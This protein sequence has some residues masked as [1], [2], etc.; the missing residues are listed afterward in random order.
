MQYTIAA[1]R[2]FPVT[3]TRAVIWK[4]ISVLKSH[5]SNLTLRRL[6][7]KLCRTVL[8]KIFLIWIL[9][10]EA[11]VRLGRMER[12]SDCQA[13][14]TASSL[15]SSAKSWA[16]V[17]AKEIWLSLQCSI[18]LQDTPSGGS[19]V[20]IVSRL[21]SNPHDRTGVRRPPHARGLG[22]AGR[23]FGLWHSHSICSL[24]RFFDL[25]IL[26]LNVARICEDNFQPKKR[27]N[28]ETNKTTPLFFAALASLTILQWNIKK[29]KHFGQKLT[30]NDIYFQI[31]AVFPST[32]IL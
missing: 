17:S 32:P 14:P 10:P 31:F 1:G 26:I 8:R 9:L 28:F 27:Y 21:D 7:N 2:P 30:K 12:C 23:G 24:A 18:V 4:S 20:A 13:Y 29:A 15:L 16:V 19:R 11:G 6:H 5:H 3:R 25:G 22:A